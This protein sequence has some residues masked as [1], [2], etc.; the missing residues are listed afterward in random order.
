LLF[1]LA[2][3]FGLSTPAPLHDGLFGS[4][5]VTWGLWRNW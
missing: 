4:V 3:S 2:S 5:E 1:F